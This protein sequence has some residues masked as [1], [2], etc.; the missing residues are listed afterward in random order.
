MVRKHTKNCA[1]P[2]VPT[3]VD[4]QVILNA[5]LAK[6]KTLRVPKKS[7]HLEHGSVSPLNFPPVAHL[8]VYSKCS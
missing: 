4:L 6:Y 8:R 7:I 5:V 2:L 1:V 3:T